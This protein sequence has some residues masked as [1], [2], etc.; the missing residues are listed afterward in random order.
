MDVWLNGEIVPEAEASISV[1]DSGLQHAVGLFETMTARHARVFRG[2]EHAQ[3]LVDSARTLL[4]SNRL[5]A[6]PLAEA[7]ERLLAHNTMSDARVRLTVT[8]GNLNMLQGRSDGHVD[9]TVLIVAQPP[10]E[11][12]P[13]FFSQGVDVAVAAGREN[14][15]TPMAGHKTLNY[16]P[17]IHALQMAG[18]IGASEAI[19][20]DPAAHLTCGCVSNIFLVRDGVILTPLA[21]G[22][23][24]AG[25]ETPPVRPG[26]SRSTVL[27]GAQALGLETR[28]TA[29]GMEDLLGADE[30]FLTNSSW[31]VLPVKGV[32]L[33]IRDEDGQPGMDARDIGSGSVGPVTSQLRRHVL[34]LIDAETRDLPGS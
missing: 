7:A 17:R 18:L 31:H 30:V 24:D 22:E 4:M 12:P 16:W 15:W 5:Q 33:P 14:P 32:R 2:R 1:F 20:L 34:D 9:P 21:R 29:L 25:Q 19:W 10:T 6:G 8:G 28:R 11:Y 27:D 3:H 26:V 13:V 23:E